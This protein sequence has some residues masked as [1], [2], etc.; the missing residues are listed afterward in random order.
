MKKTIT[1]NQPV[2]NKQLGFGLFALLK[3]KGFEQR[4]ELNPAEPFIIVDFKGNEF[5]SSATAIGTAID[6]PADYAELI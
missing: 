2:T 6:I 4:R 3:S 1:F 5:S